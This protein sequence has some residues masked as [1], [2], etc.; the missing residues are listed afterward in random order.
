MVLGNLTVIKNGVR[1]NL[2]RSKRTRAL[3][4]YLAITARPHRRDRLCAL[5]WS[6]PDDPARRCAGA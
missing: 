2:P 1:L 5:F 6:L 3:L 4:A